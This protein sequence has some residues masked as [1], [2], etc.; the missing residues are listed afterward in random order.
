MSFREHRTVKLC[1]EHFRVYVQHPLQY[2]CLENPMDREAWWVTVHG[3]AKSPT[4]LSDFTSCENVKHESTNFLPSPNHLGFLL[5]KLCPHL[6]QMYTVK[7]R[8]GDRT[9]PPN[10]QLGTYVFF[11]YL[12][13]GQTFC[14]LFFFQHEWKPLVSFCIS[15]QFVLLAISEV[16]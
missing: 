13:S 10:S 2:Y 1:S 5:W 14:T 7:E 16:A 6:P 3:V 12:F 8:A 11:T 4:R 9:S 15:L